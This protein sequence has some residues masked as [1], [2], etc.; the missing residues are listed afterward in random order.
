MP[1]DLQSNHDFADVALPSRRY[2]LAHEVIPGQVA[3]E[4][5]HTPCD[6]H[7]STQLWR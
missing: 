2:L 3:M 5:V 4:H 1:V 6:V 7:Y